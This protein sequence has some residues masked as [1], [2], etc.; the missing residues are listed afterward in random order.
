MQRL[1][2]MFRILF[3]YHPT[4]RLDLFASFPFIKRFF[5]NRNNLAVVRTFGDIAFTC[6]ILLGFFGPQDPKRNITLFLAWG[7]WWSG[8]VLSWF[9]VGKF[10]STRE[11]RWLD[12]AELV[13]E[14]ADAAERERN[15]GPGSRYA[16]VARSA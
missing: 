2:A 14:S 1:R 8:V 11:P 16:T 13:V 15:S 12:L 6:L 9:F 7:I 4:A 5:S 10:W 3:I